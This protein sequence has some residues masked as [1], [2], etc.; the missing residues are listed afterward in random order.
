MQQF[1]AIS[2]VKTKFLGDYPHM[3]NDSIEKGGE[4]LSAQAYSILK[5]MILS[6]R[7][8][9][10][11]Y[12]LEREL[13][14]LLGVSRT[15][16]RE[17]LVRLE[18][19][20]L[21]SIQPRHGIKVLPISAED[22][23]EIYQVITSL[24]CEAIYVLAEKGISGDDQTALEASTREMEQALVRDDLEAWAEADERFHQLL[25]ELCG[26]KRL[27]ETVMMYW[28]QSH[29]VRMLTLNFREKPTGSTEDH[30]AVVQ[31]IKLGQAEKAASIHRQHR[32]KGGTTLISILKKL[33]V[34]GS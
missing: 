19:E 9:I 21:I 8:S 5:A 26:N 3:V 1:V 18:H 34:A 28:G 11:V 20:G 10:G 31:A 23:A 14:E 33:P 22:M 24:E 25:V 30:T 4:S 12:Y 15:P 6:N 2:S 7:L 32:I 16:L 17:A 29:R 13:V 27:K